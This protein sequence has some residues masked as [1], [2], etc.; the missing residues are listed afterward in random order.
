[1]LL[2]LII[3]V[4]KMFVQTTNDIHE[5]IV[6]QDLDNNSIYEL[7]SMLLHW[8]VKIDLHAFNNILTIHM[9]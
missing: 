5:V 9:S 7:I 3:I 8:L 6:E 1:M 4:T 2:S